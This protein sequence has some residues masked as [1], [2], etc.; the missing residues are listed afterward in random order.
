VERDLVL[1]AVII[2]EAVVILALNH[3]PHQR[4][5]GH[6]CETCKRHA[7][8]AAAARKAEAETRAAATEADRTQAILQ[9]E[10]EHKGWGY[11]DTDPD[12]TNCRT[13]WCPRNK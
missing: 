1:T 11:Q 7:V 6:E 10:M 9:H 8:E 12:I 5:H 3:L 13:P 4:T 2:A